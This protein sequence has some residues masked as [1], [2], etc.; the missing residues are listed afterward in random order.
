[1]K[2]NIHKTQLIALVFLSASFLFIGCQKN[3]VLIESHEQTPSEVVTDWIKVYG[4]DMD[5]ASELT[6][7]EFR[8]GKAKQ[9]WASEYYKALKSAK[10]KHL[11]GKVIEE[12]IEGDKAVVVLQ[13]EID[14]VAGSAKQKEF[15]L[16]RRING[17]WLIDDIIVKEEEVEELKEKV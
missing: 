4:V 11:G 10:Y 3:P 14:T 17:E 8:E 2:R 15:Y 6:T 9:V 1:M 7:L 12:K 13:A 16:M 5:K